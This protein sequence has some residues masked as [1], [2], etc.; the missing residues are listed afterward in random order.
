[1][2]ATSPVWRALA[3][4]GASAACFAA[5]FALAGKLLDLRAARGLTRAAPAENLPPAVA[6]A[7]MA[8]GGAG[9]ILAD[10]LWLRA[11]DLQDAGRYFELSQLARWIAELQPRNAE[12]WA[13]QGWNLAYNI[14]AAVG[15]PAEKWRWVRSAISLLSDEGLER[16]GGAAAVYAE[17]AWIFLHKLSLDL[18]PAAGAYREAFAREGGTAVSE[19]TWRAMEEEAGFP[20]DR[21]IP[22]FH[23][24]HW[25]REGLSHAK[26]GAEDLALRRIA[27]QT[28]GLLVQNG[29]ARFLPW[30]RRALE[31][32][33]A[34]HPN[35]KGP[36]E[37]LSALAPGADS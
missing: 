25:A 18:D 3:A 2:K 20:L 29:D 33:V 8:F 24:L 5:A 4:A 23:A 12:V 32:T 1:M 13:F 31:E 6:F 14:P 15:D 11:G 9:G 35:A 36:K 10:A 26:T 34:R 22:A 17:L 27:Y 28:L 16:S 19:E 37:V 30:L 21:R 7:S